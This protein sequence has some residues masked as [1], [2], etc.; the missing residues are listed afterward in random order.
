[1]S[2]ITEGGLLP[3][4]IEYVPEDVQGVTPTDPAWEMPSERVTEFDPG[5]A[6]N[7]SEDTGLG[8]ADYERAPTLEE[9]E[10]SIT[11]ALQR[12]LLDG[13]GALQDMAAYGLVRVANQLPSSLS[14]VRR[15]ESG[16]LN[17]QYA[18]APLVEPSS[19][20]N[21]RYNPAALADGSDSTA[22]VT[23]AYDVLKGV[24]I[25]EATVS[26]DRENTAW[27]VDLTA[28]AEHG[29]SYR[30]D[31]P[32]TATYLTVYSQD[33]ADTNFVVYVEDEGNTTSEEITLD[34]TD[35]TTLVSSA[36]QYDNIDVVEFRDANGNVIDEDTASY[37]GPIV[38][39]VN[40]G[41]TTAPAEGEWLTV[42]WGTNDYENTYADP[43]VPALGAGSHAAPISA[44]GERPTYYSPQNL[45]VERP[46][47]TPIEHAGGVQSVELTVGNNVDRTAD[48][49]REQRQH[50]G[51][52]GFE[53][54]VTLDGET[55]STYM[56][57]ESARSVAETTRFFFN[58]ADDEWIDAQSAVVT[59]SPRGDS[60]GENSAS[61][62][63][64]ILAQRGPD[65][66]P[67]LDIS[68]AGSGP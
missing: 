53:T 3:S 56:H 67:A 30:I 20:V 68:A 9:N 28:P 33:A 38:V 47:G 41:D 31:Q 62:E 17:P 64:S 63:F 22:K 26:A 65:G 40:T 52:R 49:G 32:N 7:Y 36:N 55:V 50:H 42:G 4:R 5:Y 35:A 6:L 11:Y 15:V 37:G 25:G 66:E 10:L 61:R 39:A 60:A 29:R 24:D 57:N 58:Q 8:E 1:M 48:S 45:R 16:D 2:L 18:N 34:G 12:W 59:E 54:T 13:G 43:G 51:M 44:A 14:V 19:T 27:M 46:V 21:A 23:R